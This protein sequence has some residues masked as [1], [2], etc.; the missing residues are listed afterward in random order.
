MQI[1]ALYQVET[2][3]VGKLEKL[4]GRTSFF[5][6]QRRYARIHA[7]APNGVGY[8]KAGIL[9]HFDQL[10]RFA[11]SHGVKAIQNWG[12]GETIRCPHYW[13]GSRSN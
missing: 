9:Q 1:A 7:S 11:A 12:G 8:D 5:E 10:T 6:G 13:W 2:M 4:R 3:N